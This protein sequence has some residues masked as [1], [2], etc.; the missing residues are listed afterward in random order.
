MF[1]DLVQ[2]RDPASTGEAYPAL[3]SIGLNRFAPRVSDMD[4]TVA[5]A[6]A[7]S[8]ICDQRV[9]STISDLELVGMAPHKGA[10]H[11]RAR[12]PH[13]AHSTADPLLTAI[14]AGRI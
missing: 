3:N 5:S 4:A 6:K 11:L 2:W 8:R 14:S 7:R 12:R 1:I 9:R 13:P 10:R